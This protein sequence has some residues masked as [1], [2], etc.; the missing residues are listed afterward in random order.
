L[1]SA[2]ECRLS[3]ATMHLTRPRWRRR[4]PKPQLI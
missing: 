3:P 2:L 1:Q 4:D